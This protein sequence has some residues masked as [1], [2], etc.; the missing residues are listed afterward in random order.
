VDALFLLLPPVLGYAIGRWW[1]AW[2]FA[3]LFIVGAIV[4]AV[5]DNFV[6]ACTRPDGC[7][8]GPAAQVVLSGVLYAA[9]VAGL[10]V[11]GV[12][13]RRWRESPS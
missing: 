8:V 3:A 13:L 12:L 9:L 11:P 6:G 7:G 4:A 5:A 10:A 1:V 2:A